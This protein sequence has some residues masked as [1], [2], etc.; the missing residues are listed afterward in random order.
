MVANH[1]GGPVIPTTLDG[2]PCDRLTSIV[3]R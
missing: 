1:V 3:C 2:M